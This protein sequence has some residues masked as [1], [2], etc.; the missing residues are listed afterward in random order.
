MDAS[1]DVQT[2]LL[3]KAGV[4]RI[5]AAQPG[6]PFESARENVVSY[7]ASCWLQQCSLAYNRSGKRGVHLAPQAATL[8]QMAV[9]EIGLL[10][11]HAAPDATLFLLFQCIRAR[12]AVA[13][14]PPR[15]GGWTQI[16]GLCDGART[17]AQPRQYAHEG[18]RD[19]LGEREGRSHKGH[20]QRQRPRP[21]RAAGQPIPRSACLGIRSCATRII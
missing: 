2:A 7:L 6:V 9:E 10:C 20:G 19:A 16:R 18:S 8:R 1:R 5:T 15:R 13:I 11:W 17:N 4:S 12:V 14:L 3:A 21:P